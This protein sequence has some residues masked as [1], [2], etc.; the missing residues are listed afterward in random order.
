MLSDY[1]TRKNLD[2]HQFNKTFQTDQT[3]ISTV[4]PAGILYPM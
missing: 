1:H 4:A 2:D 3:L